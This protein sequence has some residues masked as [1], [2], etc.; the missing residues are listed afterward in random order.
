MVVI[1]NVSEKFETALKSGAGHLLKPEKALQ[2]PHIL[3]VASKK[4]SERKKICLPRAI[5]AS[6]VDKTLSPT[7]SLMLES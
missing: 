4:C 1:L 6:A 3:Y 5:A 2:T 7:Y